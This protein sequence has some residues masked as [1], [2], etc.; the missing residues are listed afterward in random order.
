MGML[1]AS[2]PMSLCRSCGASPSEVPPAL[3]YNHFLVTTQ[4]DI[5]ETFLASY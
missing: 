4:T 5:A 3:H 1:R 2:T